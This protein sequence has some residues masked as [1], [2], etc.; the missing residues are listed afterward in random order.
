MRSTSCTPSSTSSSARVELPVAA[1]RAEHRPQRA[2][3]AVHVE[4]HLDELRDDALHLLVGRPLLHDNNH[5]YLCSQVLRASSDVRLSNSAHSTPPSAIRSSRRAS[6]MM[7]SNSRLIAPS[8]SGPALT[9]CTCVEHFG[10][11][12]R[13]VDA[14]AR[15]A[16]S[17]ARSRART[18]RAR[19]AAGR[20][21]RR[22][23]RCAG[24]DRRARLTPRSSASARTRRRAPATSRGVPCSAI[25]FTSALPT[26]AASAERAGFGDLLGR[27]DAEADRD[28]AAPT[29]PRTRA[30]ERSASAASRSRAPVTPSREM[31]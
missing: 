26:T 20:A 18:P 14:R 1:D 5:R 24:A 7:R 25:T 31:T 17:R 27:R 15:L 21:A 3:R 16:S 10:L 28:A 23:R 30:D 9:R 12:R 19:S 11:A 29:A 22:A 2:G 4:A 6:S 13:L 8:S